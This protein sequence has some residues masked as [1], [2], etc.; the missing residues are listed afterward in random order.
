MSNIVNRW[1]SIKH[2]VNIEVRDKKSY[3]TK[4]SD[5]DSTIDLIF[6]TPA[7]LCES[8]QQNSLFRLEN[9]CNVYQNN[10]QM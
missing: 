6:R 4:K 8:I 9:T 2:C 3:S 10:I 7:Y 1:S 5:I